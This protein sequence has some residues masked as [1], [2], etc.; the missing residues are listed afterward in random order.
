MRPVDAR[1]LDL[2]GGGNRAGQRRLQRLCGGKHVR[3]GRA[4][5]RQRATGFVALDVAHGQQRVVQTAD[6]LRR[7]QGV[8]RWQPRIAVRQIRAEPAPRL[9][10]SHRLFVAEWRRVVRGQRQVVVEPAETVLAIDDQFGHLLRAHLDAVDADGGQLGMRDLVDAGVD[11]GGFGVRAVERDAARGNRLGLELR[12]QMRQRVDD[13]FDRRLELAHAFLVTREQGDGQR[14][15]RFGNL[16]LQD[17]Q[18]R[19][20]LGRDQDAFAR[21][22]IVTD[23]VGDRVRLA[24]AGRTLHR[25]A[26]RTFQLLDDGFL[27]AVVR[28]R[29]VQLARLAGIDGAAGQAAKRNRLV[30]EHRAAGRRDKAQRPVR[31]CFGVVHAVFQARDVVDQ[32]VRRTRPGEDHPAMRDDEALARGRRLRG[33]HVVA[34]VGADLAGDQ[35]E[36]RLDHL[37]CERRERAVAARGQ[38]AARRTFDVADPGHAAG[39]ERIEFQVRVELAGPQADGVRG[40]VD[41]DF[42]RLRDERVMEVDR[43]RGAHLPRRQAHAP[44][45]FQRARRFFGFEPGLQREQVRVQRDHLA[46]RTLARRPFLPRRQVGSQP[47]R[48]AGAAL[49]IAFFNALL[50]LIVGGM[51]GIFMAGVCQRG[52]I[53]RRRIAGRVGADQQIGRQRRIGQQRR[54]CGLEPVHAQPQVI[55]LGLDVE[56]DPR[57]RRQVGK[58]FLEFGDFRERERGRVYVFGLLDEIVEQRAHALGRCVHRVLPGRAGG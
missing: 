23:D 55:L 51:R 34:R 40:R 31:Q 6:G 46:A 38:Q 54:R 15:D 3:R 35:L 47:L 53:E 11:G 1:S 50:R 26:G 2:G 42:Q 30:F 21:G 56:F 39:R 28:Q 37:G 17:L 57:Q 19:L 49:C 14:P 7:W 48:G 36:D 22:Q 33:G 8:G 43:R 5:R 12:V 32:E 13:R 27:L 41:V 58:G 9:A 24:G 16:L 18:R 10:Q 45:Q 52:V 44:D 29:E 25:D 4:Q 20:A